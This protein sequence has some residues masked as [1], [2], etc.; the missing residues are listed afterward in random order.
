LGKEALLSV[1]AIEGAM[2]LLRRPAMAGAVPRVDAGRTA[3]VMVRSLDELLCGIGG[4]A[5]A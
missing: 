3:W 2:L 5:G 1:E 4:M